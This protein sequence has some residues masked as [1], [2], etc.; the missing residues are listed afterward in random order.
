MTKPIQTQAE[1][2]TERFNF[3]APLLSDG[4]DKG[5]RS[6]LMCEIAEK[7]GKSEKTIKR[8]VDAWKEGGYEA[9][10]PKQGWERSDSSHD[11]SF[12]LVVDAAIE[13]RRESPSR[14]VADIIKIMELEDAI[15]TGSVA[16]S[17]LQRHLAARGYASSQMKMYVSK[18][19]AARRFKKEKR[20]QLWQTDFKYGPFVADEKKQNRQIYFIAWIDNATRY[21]IS[22]GFY[23]YQTELVVEDSLRLGIQKYGLPD[24]IFKDQGPSF[25]SARLARICAKLGIRNLSTR[26]YHPEANGVAE[27]FNKQIVKFISEAVLR[28]CLLSLQPPTNKVL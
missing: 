16:R 14:S 2:A 22:A 10:K 26:P 23:Y 4:L 18:G 9:L 3:I 12:E 25:R 19:T 20:N 17:T 13:L 8:Y 15:P 6:D 21:I 28:T 1:V 7:S 24:G 11:D 27:S 5:R